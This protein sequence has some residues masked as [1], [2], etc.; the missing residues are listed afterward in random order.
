MSRPTPN[1]SYMPDPNGW[2]ETAPPSSSSRSKSTRKPTQRPLL[3]FSHGLVTSVSS[4]Y[5]RPTH[6]YNTNTSSISKTGAG[7]GPSTLL[8]RRRGLE[9]DTPSNNAFTAK[10][11]GNAS[12]RKSGQGTLNNF[13]SPPTTAGPSPRRSNVRTNNDPKTGK[14]ENYKEFTEDT[15]A[16]NVMR[17]PL[18]MRASPRLFA[19]TEPIKRGLVFERSSKE[20]GKGKGAARI[21]VYK[22]DFWNSSSSDTDEA[23]K[24][25]DATCA[26]VPK[27][28][29]RRNNRDKLDESKQADSKVQGRTSSKS[30]DLAEDRHPA[31]PQ[32]GPTNAADCIRLQREDRPSSSPPL[33]SPSRMKTHLPMPEPHPKARDAQTARTTPSS[34]PRGAD[35]S[36]PPPITPVPPHI[37]ANHLQ[38]C[39]RDPAEANKIRA[40][41]NTHQDP[42]KTLKSATSDRR[43]DTEEPG[44]VDAQTKKRKRGTRLDAAI[45]EVD[46]R[47][48]EAA[49]VK[50]HVTP[51][52]EARDH[53]HDH[54]HEGKKLVDLSSSDPVDVEEK[55]LVDLT[56][57]DP[58][59]EAPQ[60]DSKRARIEGG[61]TKTGKK[62]AAAADM[63]TSRGPLTPIKKNTSAPLGKTI[64]SS[65]IGRRSPGGQGNR[66]ASAKKK[67]RISAATPLPRTSV[68]QASVTD[69]PH[70]RASN[71][72]HNTTTKS[73]P[74]AANVIMENNDVDIE[75]KIEG[76]I[77][78]ARA[79]EQRLERSLRQ[80]G[81]EASQ[82]SQR[83]KSQRHRQPSLSPSPVAPP[84]PQVDVDN[85]HASSPIPSPIHMA[86]EAHELTSSP[87]LL[88]T[89]KKSRQHHNEEAA[90]RHRVTPPKP[91]FPFKAMTDRQETLFEFPAPPP[92]PE[93]R[94]S[95]PHEQGRAREWKV[96]EMQPETLITW[97]LGEPSIDAEPDVTSSEIQPEGNDIREDKGLIGQERRF[98][99]SHS[100]E[101]PLF[102]DQESS[103][104]PGV[105]GAQRPS[106]G[107]KWSS[108]S[109][110]PTAFSQVFPVLIPTSPISEKGPTPP[111]P[112]LAPRHRSTR[113]AV[114]AAPAL[115]EN[116][117]TTTNGQPREGKEDAETPMRATGKAKWDHL[118]RGILAP[119]PSKPFAPRE[120]SRHTP[121]AQLSKKRKTRSPPTS[122]PGRNDKGGEQSKLAAFGFFGADP[123][124]RAIAKRR[125][126]QAGSGGDGDGFG[127]GWHDEEDH[128]FAE[129]ESRLS[130]P[131]YAIQDRDR[132]LGAEGREGVK[133]GKGKDRSLGKVPEAPPHPALRPAGIREL[134]RRAKANATG[135]AAAQDHAS[136]SR[137][138]RDIAS[139]SDVNRPE[140]EGQVLQEA[141]D[142]SMTPLSVAN[143]RFKMLMEDH[144][145]EHDFDNE[146]ENENDIDE[147]PLFGP[148]SPVSAD[149]LGLA[150]GSGSG[151]G[152]GSRR[153]SASG[154]DPGSDSGHSLT[155][156]SQSGPA[157]GWRT[158][159]STRAWWD[160]LDKRRGSEFGT[161][162]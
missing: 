83:E 104:I 130:S 119:T 64:S 112:Q 122:T 35:T 49:H 15:G 89:P 140:S 146:I 84:S 10:R 79:N 137:T 45:D 1:S 116:G 92:R 32:H 136:A 128:D 114:G 53:D 75:S 43:K 58:V 72:D 3:S 63:T 38:L 23:E 144:D 105:N 149:L 20:K 37:F 50:R 135:A 7:P 46:R 101:P 6:T 24:D 57:S 42:K 87:H 98:E 103:P 113:A 97:G 16:R 36:P 25:D 133:K 5:K 108:K 39:G 77:E 120:Q 12:T 154:P 109:I 106:P 96:A 18:S 90:K 33:F 134:E 127:R 118:S 41:W 2:I 9:N 131:S 28:T 31:S 123:A 100:P 88:V 54:G 126:R 48:W 125:K 143:R 44:V 81:K 19:Q 155:S 138:D 52:G 73:P 157:D 93:Y 159:G 124:S 110:E 147:E 11:S 94:L 59:E 60:P 142:E 156:S 152:S 161:V 153:S 21:K 4:G 141:S 14:G 150:H 66:P 67:A 56:S 111:R 27:L 82:A 86:P 107:H 69:I 102:S 160:G 80:I 71:P 65:M 145:H 95:S 85:H 26:R 148:A 61:A 62:D 117:N 22:D 162:E 8:A 91:R 132:D 29:Q 74:P 129:A 30:I 55:K 47:V 13:F 76:V 40:S 51:P 158:P 99:G 151:S 121:S 34:P 115:D 78:E 139:P 17:T 70:S 68:R